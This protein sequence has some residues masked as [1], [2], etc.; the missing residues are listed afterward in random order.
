MSRAI[1]AARHCERSRT[2]TP[3]GAGHP[4]PDQPGAAKPPGCP[5]THSH[6]DFDESLASGTGLRKKS[7]TST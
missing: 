6:A 3:P 2:V 7:T 4:V 1:P 5:I